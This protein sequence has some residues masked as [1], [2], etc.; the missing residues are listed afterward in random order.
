MSSL[1]DLPELIGFFSYSREDDADSHGALSAL[2]NRIQGEL[3]GL[4]GRTAKTFRL[5]QDKEAIP[6]GTLWESE[7]KSAAAQS[8]FFVPIITPTVVASPYCRFELESFLAREAELGRGDLVFPILYIDVPALDDAVRRQ[9]DPVL[10]LI[11]SR[12]YL[13]WRELR[14]LDIDS[15]EV[16]RQ[17]GRF[18]THIR[19]ALQRPWMSPEE[20]KAQEVA[21]RQGEAERRQQETESKRRAEVERHPTAEFEAEARTDV[22]QLRHEAEAQPQR[23][24]A[25]RQKP[26]QPQLREKVEVQPHPEE[27]ARRVIR[28]LVGLLVGLFVV[29]AAIGIW[30]VSTSPPTTTPIKVTILTVQQEQNLKA[31]D[32]FKECT[33]CPQMMVVSAGSFSLGSPA[34]EPARFANEGPQHTVKIARQ[35]AVGQFALTFDE[36]DACVGAGGCNG[37]RP[38]DQ[39]WGRGGRPVINVSWHDAAA[40]V[41][42]LAKLT[43]KPYRLL[44][45]AEYEY[46]TRAGTTTAYPWGSAIGKN[47]AN[48]HGCSSE[49][50]NKQ[51]APVGSFAANGFGLYDMV[52]NV[53]EWTQDC[54]HD[55]YDGAP[56]DGS[57]WISGDCG[58]RVL[59][60]GSWYRDP[61]NLRSALR[62]GV[63][64]D[65]RNYGVGFRVARTLLTP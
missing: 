41:A 26:A 60:G 21:R 4:L 14:Y 43:G 59:R 61:D 45:E 37:Y 18:C 44:S 57:A 2:R 25:E 40:Y 49:W 51:T 55:G 38:D 47:N 16:K 6:A 9:N 33:T 5:W 3:R 17:V 28:P 31:K 39:G 58:S 29:L 36:W 62:F 30:I 48:C 54:Y 24:E 32:T 50:D 15:T 27:D 7:I 1:A 13:D 22:E 56:T 8:V 35:F 42:W 10:S 19:D 64:S 52:G 63:T 20:R 46:A 34:G 65:L 12:Q 11:A 53:W 23:A